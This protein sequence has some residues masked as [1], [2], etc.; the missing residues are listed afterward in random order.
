MNSDTAVASASY[1]YNPICSAVQ[2]QAAQEVVT[3]LLGGVSEVRREWKAKAGDD[4]CLVSIV[5]I[6]ES[7][8]THTY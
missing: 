3:F 1:A 8:G 2:E 5:H 7:Y 6:Y 4:P